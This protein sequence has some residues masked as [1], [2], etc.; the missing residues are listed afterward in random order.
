MQNRTD[1]IHDIYDNFSGNANDEITTIDREKT[2]R[3]K[4]LEMEEWASPVIYTEDEE[5]EEEEG[6]DGDSTVEQANTA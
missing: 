2:A 1:T 6:E 5:E 4:L 3:R